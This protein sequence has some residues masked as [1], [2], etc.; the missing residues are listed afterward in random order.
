MAAPIKDTD[1]ASD[2]ISKLLPADITAAFL[3]ARAGLNGFF[4]DA[5]TS[6]G[7]VFWT[8]VIILVL[9][10]L[11]FWFASDVRKIYHV[12]FLALSF[13]VFS[14]SIAAS[15]FSVFL[16]QNHVPDANTYTNAVAIVLPAVWAFI[17]TPIVA[18]NINVPK[19]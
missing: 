6:A 3:S 5:A 19:P 14:I 15:D 16:S 1:T 2:R 18:R 10:P 8:F 13:A 9:C 11:Y 12:A 7:F 4:Q 17:V